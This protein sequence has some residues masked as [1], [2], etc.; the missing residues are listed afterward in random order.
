M[1]FRYTARTKAGELQTGNINASSRE[2]ALGTLTQHELFVVELTQSLEIGWYVKLV[3]HFNR[4]KIKDLMVFTR[5]FATLLE[6]RVPIG[7]ALRT[8]YKQT[9]SSHLKEVVFS[10]ASDIDSGLSLSQALDRYSD[11]FGEFYVSMVQSAEVTGRMDEVLV[12]LADYIEKEHGLISRVRSA[13]IYP[14]VVISLFAVVGGIVVLVIVPALAPLFEESKIELPLFTRIL[15]GTAGF[16]KSWWWLLLIVVSGFGIF[17]FDYVRTP[18]GKAVVDELKLKIPVLGNLLKKLYVARVGESVGVLLKGG[19]ATTQ[20]IEIA[21]HTVGNYVYSDLLHE[22]AER[23]NGGELM[24]QAFSHYPEYFPPLISQMVAVGENTG[25]LDDMLHRVAKFY[26][27]EVDN[28][29][30][31]LVELI[32]PLL[33]VV[34]GILTG[35]LFA[36]MLL[37]IYDLANTMR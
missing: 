33:I 34:I 12:F 22:I 36:S 6:A 8:L 21:S 1:K 29:V 28:V 35:L 15:L 7:D 2:R 30:A 19:I 3:S 13:L 16:I 31:N 9:S 32:Q 5:Q 11:V 26:T 4:V 27:S 14:A 37:P 10:M 25:R 20:S 18:E 23:I 17:G 24:S